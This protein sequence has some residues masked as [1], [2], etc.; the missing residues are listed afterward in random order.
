MSYVLLPFLLFGLHCHP[1]KSRAQ[2]DGFE[3][4]SITSTYQKDATSA[5]ADAAK[6]RAHIN[7]NYKQ[8]IGV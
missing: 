3:P 4:S 2:A 8:V 1:S 5:H 6:W 7:A